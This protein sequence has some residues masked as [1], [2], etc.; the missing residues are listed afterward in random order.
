M[1]PRMPDFAIVHKIVQTGERLARR[2]VE[3]INRAVR[4]DCGAKM[5]VL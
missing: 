4:V 1:R 3:Q 2:F 5:F